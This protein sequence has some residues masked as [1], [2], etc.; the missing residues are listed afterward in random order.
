M[1][2]LSIENINKLSKDFDDSLV[3]K[4]T[5]YKVCVYLELHPYSHA[6]F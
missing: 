2:I 6:G 4:L 3:E 1:M 5:L